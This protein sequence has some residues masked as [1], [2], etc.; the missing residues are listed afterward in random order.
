MPKPFS[1]LFLLRSEVQN[2][3]KRLYFRVKFSKCFKRQ[4]AYS[5]V[6][7]NADANK[8]SIFCKNRGSNCTL[9]AA[10]FLKYFLQK[11]THLSYILFY[12]ADKWYSFNQKQLKT[13][14]CYHFTKKFE[15][16]QYG[17]FFQLLKKLNFVS[18]IVFP[19]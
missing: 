11:L 19:L 4:Y 3:L 2:T 10:N 8:F 16:S 6:D 12:V 15:V 9:Y 1:P 18:L 14:T 17:M 13:F 7:C 5:T